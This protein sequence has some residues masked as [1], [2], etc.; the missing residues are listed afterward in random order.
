MIMCISNKTGKP[1]KSYATESDAIY[2]AQK[3]SEQYGKNLT[4]YR[5]NKCNQYHLTPKERDTPSSDC[6]VCSWSNSSKPK[7]LYPNEES[8]RLRASIIYEE[9]GVRLKV[10]PCRYN[11]GYHLTKNQ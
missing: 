5:C 4:H 7:K 6:D 3:S 8:A 9:D 2:H 1:L 11:A 10:Y